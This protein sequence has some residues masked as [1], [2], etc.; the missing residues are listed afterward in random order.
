MPDRPGAQAKGIAD[1]DGGLITSADG[2]VGIEFPD[3]AAS[4]KLDVTITRLA[5]G[6][7]NAPSPDR[8]FVGVWDFRAASAQTRAEVREF[9]KPLKVTL[10]FSSDDFEGLDPRNLVFW[11]LDETSGAWTHVPAEVDAASRTMVAETDHFTVYSAT[12]SELVNTAPLLDG[13][14]VDLQ[15]G[16]A[17]F[18]IPLELPPG[19]GGLK[20]QLS[21]TYSSSRLG[22]MRTYASGTSWVGAGWDL[23]VPNIQFQFDPNYEPRA[24]QRHRAFLSLNGIGGEMLQDPNGAQDADGYIWRMR[25]EQY[26]KVRSSCDYFGCSDGWTVWDKNGTKYVFGVGAWNSNY[27]R[28]YYQRVS[29]NM[30]YIRPYRLDITYIEDIYGNRIDFTYWQQRL[31]D[32]Q[33]PNDEYVMAAYPF[34]IIYNGGEAVINFHRGCDQTPASPAVCM[35]YD[36]PRDV[37]NGGCSYYA[38]EVLETQR[39]NQIEVKVSNTLVRRYDFTYQT[40]PF[41]A[42]GCPA[43]PMR[44]TGTHRLLNVKML[45]RNY[46]SYPFTTTSFQY[47]NKHQAYL[48][49][50]DSEIY[51]YDW[52]YLTRVDN[53][54]GGG[55]L[56]TYQE[57]G[58]IDTG[59][60]WSRS[61][62]TEERRQPGASQPDVHTTINYGPG[63]DQQN[64]PNPLKP[65]T[66]DTFNAEY[67]GFNFATEV[68]SAGNK[69]EHY[70]YTTG[71]WA[72]DVRSGREYNTIARDAANVQW[73]RTQTTWSI[74]T[75]SNQKNATDYFVN[76][77]YPSQT[78][79]TLKDG[80]ALTTVNTFDDGAS[81]ASTPCYGL[82]TQVDEQG[83]AG[84][85]DRVVTNTAYHKNTTKWL[86]P[87]KYVEKLDVDNGN[88]LLSCSRTYY[89]GANNANALPT[90]GLATATSVAINATAAQCEGATVFTSSTNTY[91]VYETYGSPLKTYGNAAQV[92]VPTSSAPEY[93]TAGGAF[94]WLP[95][96]LAYSST[97]YDA[98]HHLFPTSETNPLGQTTTIAY[99]YVLGKPTVVTE[100]NG[101]T[102]TI[103]Y[104]S[105]G[106]I[107]RWYDNL[108]SDAWPTERYTYTWGSVPNKTLV[109]KRSVQG[110]AGAVRKSTSCLDGF[111]REFERRESFNGP[112][113]ASVRVDYDARGLKVAESNPVDIGDVPNCSA[114]PDPVFARDR[115]VFTYDPL[116]N[117]VKTMFVA[118]NQSTGPFT[119]AIFNG[120]T[121]STVDELG[122]RTDQAR[123]YT[124]RTLTVTEPST[125]TLSTVLRPSGQGAYSEWAFATPNQAHYLNVQEAVADNDASQFNDQWWYRKDTQSYPGAGLSGGATIVRVSF[126]FRWKHYDNY[127]PNPG[128]GMWAIFRQNGVDTRGPAYQS[129]NAAGWRDDQWDMTVNPRTGQPWTVAELNAGLEFGFEIYPSGGAWNYITQTYVEIVTLTASGASTIYHYDALGR[130]IDV[131][132][133]LGNS[134]SITYDLTGRKTAMSDP[135]MGSWTYAYNAA[136]SLTSQTD[137]RGVITNL[138]YD[139]A[140]RL[141]RKTYTNGD[142]PVSFLY[143][144]YPDTQ[145]CT[146]PAATAIG[147]MTRMTD[148]SG[149][150]FGC[151]DVRG[152]A[153]QS[154]RSVDGVNYDVSTSY[155]PLNQ[156]AQVT[157]P[158][159]EIVAYQRATEGNVTGLSSQPAGQPSQ[160]LLS[161]AVAKPWGALATL[162]LGNGLA[163]PRSLYQ[164]L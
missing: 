20:P 31:P 45:D 62:V 92:S 162:P 131:T 138:T 157:Y 59:N 66:Q 116:G 108:D 55:V 91:T 40:D 3:G 126:K 10:R 103:V 44:T 18:A 129:T 134:T 133:A 47:T 145:W 163:C 128:P 137:A 95:P 63:P 68:D 39:L 83:E 149:Q 118:A 139:P 53:A 87:T 155:D 143:D 4:E 21:L 69:V 90:L 135:D 132:D 161:N 84:A 67:R 65:T 9:G 30:W 142:A 154:R 36:T 46:V 23:D 75:V 72:D 13:K 51:A 48:N 1:L 164:S 85:G 111:G 38:P 123:S 7:F 144:S 73:Q 71:V 104:D 22:E 115:K 33:K 147:V 141:T 109:E 159:G 11:T 100:P 25:D 5:N 24:Q 122:N 130:L 120:K 16:A 76:F 17:S 54:F 52:P 28:F 82:L 125:S 156:P 114:T 60:H 107:S 160:T 50:A 140:E 101:Q 58:R 32:P 151:Y 113:R 89:D 112:S 6:D 2:R 119:Q 15:S 158:D 81:C 70:F 136:G 99:D 41:A 148:V 12:A 35:R 49:D 56:F 105:L 98:T 74:R 121:T 152:R 80:T 79:A 14:N 26:L 42:S 127:T 61:V 110:M 94:G 150:Q 27:S 29:A 64:Y 88:A 8:P 146:Q 78:V 34:Q 102:K 19:R 153:V 86:F 124:G 97:V 37:I 77:I 117:V 106:R 96:G 57:L 43:T 93:Q